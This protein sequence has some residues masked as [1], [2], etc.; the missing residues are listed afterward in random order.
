MRPA[1]FQSLRIVA[2]PGANRG[3]D[4]AQIIDMPVHGLFRAEVSGNT[5]PHAAGA[6]GA[7]DVEIISRYD[8]EAAPATYFHPGTDIALKNQHVGPWISFHCTLPLTS[9][10]PRDLHSG[11]RVN[12]PHQRTS[13]VTTPTVQHAVAPQLLPKGLAGYTRRLPVRI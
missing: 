6:E 12:Q 7:A 9:I 10:H 2:A 4:L 13:T 3:Q 5:S 1:V 11:E 8:I